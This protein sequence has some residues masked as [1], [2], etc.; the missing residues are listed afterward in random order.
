MNPTEDLPWLEAFSAVPNV[1]KFER[2]AIVWQALTLWCTHLITKLPSWRRK[3]LFLA[4]TEINVGVFCWF[5]SE[6]ND[7]CNAFTIHSDCISIQLQHNRTSVTNS[8]QHQLWYDWLP[9]PPSELTSSDAE[10]CNTRQSVFNSLCLH[11]HNPD[12]GDTKAT[13]KSIKT[14][15]CFLAL[16]ASTTSWVAP[17]PGTNFDKK[18]NHCF[19]INH[20]LNTEWLEASLESL[21]RQAGSFLWRRQ[22]K[23]I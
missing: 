18:T 1:F 17:R 3:L 16:P 14:Q 20:L 12:K 11:K 13:W 15:N 23:E 19:G 7:H 10:S 22:Q 5:L 9:P 6:I 8:E 21:E 4:L 2:T